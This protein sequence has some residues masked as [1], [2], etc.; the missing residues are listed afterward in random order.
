MLGW[1]QLPL[2]RHVL[3]RVPNSGWCSNR[4]GTTPHVREPPGSSGYPYCE[5]PDR[6]SRLC[7]P[8]EH[9]ERVSPQIIDR[10]PEK[11]GG[12]G[13]CV[14]MM[15]GAFAFW[16]ISPA[17]QL[18]G[19]FTAHGD[20][21]HLTVPCYSPGRIGLWRWRWRWQPGGPGQHTLDGLRACGGSLAGPR[22]T[23]VGDVRDR[24]LCRRS[25]RRR[26]CQSL[27]RRQRRL[28]DSCGRRHS[29]ARMSTYEYSSSARHSRHVKCLTRCHCRA[30]QPSRYR[31]AGPAFDRDKLVSLVRMAVSRVSPFRT[32]RPLL[33]FLTRMTAHRVRPRLSQA[34]LTFMCKD[35]LRANLHRHCRCGGWMCVFSGCYFP[36]VA[37]S[38][39]DARPCLTQMSVALSRNRHGHKG[40]FSFNYLYLNHSSKKQKWHL[41]RGA[42]GLPV[43]YT[44]CFSAAIRFD[45]QE[46]R[47]LPVLSADNP[48]RLLLHT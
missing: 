11:S 23:R 38:P 20:D 30:M 41:F 33:G 44:R 24:S 8:T 47:T 34:I 43:G 31:K 39:A 1:A 26:I 32:N 4:H 25:T 5:V 28:G 29:R 9:G 35:D 42:L 27:G 3:H 18:P 7:P 17:G 37:K 15:S 10:P 46:S 48:D 16:A 14:D 21:P 40:D 13:R 6:L 2:I 22:P 19:E 45:V 12:T 36:A